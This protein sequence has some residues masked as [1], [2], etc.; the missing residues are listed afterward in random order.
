MWAMLVLFT[1]WAFFNGTA[2]LNP[3]RGIHEVNNLVKRGIHH[4]VYL[5]DFRKTPPEKLKTILREPVE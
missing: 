5:S 3:F 4:E 1:S 2:S